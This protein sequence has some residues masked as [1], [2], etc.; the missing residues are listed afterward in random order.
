MEK[1]KGLLP[2]LYGTCAGR[3]VLRVL[4]SRTV[5]NAVG[6]FMDSA[7][8]R[9][10][11]PGFIRKNGID[12]A[13]YE[14]RPFRSFNDFFTRRV[15]SEKRPVDMRDSRFI[16]PCDGRLSA[17]RI[18]ADLV[19][20]VKGIPY[21]V[22]QILDGDERA[23]LFDG[24][25]CLVFRLCVDDYHRYH[26]VDGGTAQPARK[27]PG[28]LHTVR[29][30]ALA[31]EKVFA[32]NSREITFVETDNFG[33]VA[34]VEVG[35]MLVGRIC[36]TA[37]PGRV[38][39]GSEKGCFRFG[40]STVVLFTQKGRVGIPEELFEATRRGGETRVRMGEAVG[41]APGCPQGAA[42]AG[43]GK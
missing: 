1:E 34:Y 3:A 27:V 26:F 22:R 25:A 32:R 7:L 14:D 31:R 9:P 11:I 42:P 20:R 40:G 43:G 38:E 39:R 33:T 35:A 16:S 10:L 30:V 8:S 41:Y 23:A 37:A 17:Y 5:S 21:T 19:F 36:N 4:V 6:L 29:P 15:R 18:G 12:M 24:G 28:V 13:D 2:F